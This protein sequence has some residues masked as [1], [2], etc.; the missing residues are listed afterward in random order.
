[1]NEGDEFV[2]STETR[3]RKRKPRHRFSRKKVLERSRLS[4][5]NAK[6][7]KKVLSYPAQVDLHSLNLLKSLLE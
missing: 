6:A 1:M 5:S 4:K 2:L 7:V 3:K